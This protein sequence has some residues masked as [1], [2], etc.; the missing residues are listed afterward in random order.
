MIKKRSISIL[1]DS[2]VFSALEKR[3]KRELMSLR[4]LLTDIL[5]RSVIASKRKGYEE[6]KIEDKFIE[7]FSRHPAG[8]KRKKG[9]KK[10]K[11]KSK[12]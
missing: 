2:E 8:R 12:K 1:V 7:Y 4:E 9:K 10:G 3:A 11:K 5:R 6:P